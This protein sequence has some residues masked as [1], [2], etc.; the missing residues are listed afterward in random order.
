MRVHNELGTGFQEVIC[1]RSLAIELGL[2]GLTYERAKEQAIYL[3][4]QP[5]WNKTR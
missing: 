2:E 4:R 1:Q 5:S 3:Q